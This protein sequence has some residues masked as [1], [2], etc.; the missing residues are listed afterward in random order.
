VD[1]RTV[2]DG[3]GLSYKN[4]YKVRHK[5]EQMFRRYGI[6]GIEDKISALAK[7]EAYEQAQMANSYKTATP[8]ANSN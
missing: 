7:Q 5:T 8:G 2:L 6:V 4:S 3:L 1:G